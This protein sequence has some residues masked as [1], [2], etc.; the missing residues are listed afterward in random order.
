MSGN[1]NDRICVLE[2]DSI[3]AYW[4]LYGYRSLLTDSWSAASFSQQ[5]RTWLT[6]SPAYSLYPPRNLSTVRAGPWPPI[7]LGRKD[8][9]EVIRLA[10]SQP[11]KADHTDVWTGE[12]CVTILALIAGRNAVCSTDG[13]SACKHKGD[14]WGRQQFWFKIQSNVSC[15]TI[16]LWLSQNPVARQYRTALLRWSNTLSQSNLWKERVYFNLKVIVRAG[17]KQ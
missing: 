2:H 14:R 3:P 15:L 12:P 7:S 1:R 8:T 10:I 4:I 5:P 6:F 11:S 17:I 16:F 9:G 13:K